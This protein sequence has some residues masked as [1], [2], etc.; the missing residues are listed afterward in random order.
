MIQYQE[1]AVMVK[2]IGL[3]DIIKGEKILIVTEIKVAEDDR[4]RRHDGCTSIT[5]I[6]TTPIFQRAEIGS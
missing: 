1:E 3:V 5:Y 6:I 4:T 2:L